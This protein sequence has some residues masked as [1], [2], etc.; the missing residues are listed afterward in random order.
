MA[1]DRARRL[2]VGVDVGTTGTK[3]AVLD[4]ERGEVLTEAQPSR[5]WSPQ[6][7]A[8]EADPQEWW[9]NLCA[10]IPRV[11]ARTGATAEVE[12]VAVTGM[13]PALVVSDRKGR[14]LRRALL[15]N[16]ARAVREI[17][18]VKSRL[19][20]VDVVAITG[21]AVSQQSIGPKLLWLAAHEPEVLEAAGSVMGSYEW[22]ACALGAPPHLEPNWALESGLFDLDGTPFAP[23]LEASGV[24]P[25][26]LPG[27][28][29]SASRV[30]AVSKRAAEATGLREGTPIV[31]GGAD[32]VLAAYAAGLT[33]PGDWLVKLGGAGDILAVS[34]DGIVDGRIYLDHHA[35]P[36]L[37][38]PN[39]CMATSGSMLRWVQQLLGG[40]D[41]AELDGEAEA[42]APGAVICLPHFLGEKS[43]LHDPALRGAFV[44]LHL[45]HSRADVY[46]SCLE[47]VA[48]GMRQHVEIFEELGL[49]LDEALVTNGGSKSMLWKQILA[50]VLG[51]PLATI[52]A[53]D[54]ASVG[55][56]IVAG[57]GSGSIGWDFPQRL[58]RREAVIRPDPR[59]AARYE[60]TYRVFGE[61]QKAVT[62]IAHALSRGA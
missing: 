20:G 4:P 61:A 54:G 14:P 45:G 30:G 11:L 8:A 9:T 39:G 34:E 23:A 44:G 27:V 41:L 25:A 1:P 33:K 3:V 51:R 60:D 32:H 10:L 55:A 22:A 36:G 13:V 18:G 59:N 62:P 2:L 17:D 24:D 38:L 5:L 37:W 16:D 56:A 49:E 50:D 31:V 15:Q 12:A 43:P 47:A 42:A 29:P 53:S 57:V 46:R 35:I 40:A 48:F 52:A 26:V 28:V 21:S 58:V 6:P 19:A 7:G